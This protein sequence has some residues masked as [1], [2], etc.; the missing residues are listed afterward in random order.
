M[1][2]H[3]K[4]R[5]IRYRGPAQY[6]DVERERGHDSKR[7]GCVRLKHGTMT[8]LSQVVCINYGFIIVVSKNM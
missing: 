6:V 3:E 5:N 7:S 8:G 2:L 1:A 4:Q